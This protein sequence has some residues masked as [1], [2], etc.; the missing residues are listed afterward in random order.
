MSTLFSIKNRWTSMSLAVTICSI[1]PIGLVFYQQYIGEYSVI[2]A[3]SP[4]AAEIF[5]DGKAIGKTPVKID[6]KKGPYTLT[7]QKSGYEPLEH[8][9]FVDPQKENLVNIQLLPS[10]M[11][12]NT[13][14][15]NS[16]SIIATP[17]IQKLSEEVQKLRSIIVV[18]P[19]SAATIPILTEKVLI[20]G[21]SLKALREELK[22]VR[23]QGKW[24]LGSMIAIIV[25]LLGVIASLFISNK[26]K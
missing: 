1:V 2:V 20:Q 8:A 15:G 26:G 9:I 14:Q 21:E 11:P 16:A 18:D 25:G 17:D 10:P 7:A 19:E 12:S 22:D 6:L 5:F 23:E 3:S 24:Y 13:T 4:A